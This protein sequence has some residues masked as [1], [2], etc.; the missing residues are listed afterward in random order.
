M[1]C[2]ISIEPT[3][4]F[5]RLM[6]SDKPDW[7]DKVE[8]N[9]SCCLALIERLPAASPRFL[10]EGILFILRADGRVSEDL[11]ISWTFPSESGLYRI[12]NW[13]RC[14]VSWNFSRRYC[15]T[16]SRFVRAFDKWGD[17]TSCVVS[18]D[19]NDR[20]HR[21]GYKMGL[22]K[23]RVEISHS[24]SLKFVSTSPENLETTFSCVL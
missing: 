16:F 19:F 18:G 22:N 21:A 15:S 9:I 11:G 10:D 12:C 2:P 5:S 8:S 17:E 6:H 1:S 23:L 20:R 14:I 7:L 3:H 24:I 4:L 13:N